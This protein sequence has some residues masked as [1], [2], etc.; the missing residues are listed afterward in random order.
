MMHRLLLSLVL[1][2]CCLP[3]CSTL[4]KNRQV[5]ISVH[6]QGTEMANPKSIFKR[7][8]GGR[9]MIFQTLPVFTHNNVIAFHPFPAD[10]GTNGVALK[11]DFKGTHAL[12]M[13]TRMRRGEVLMA[14]VNLSVVD[15][16]NIDQAVSD[17][18]FT[19]WQGIPDELIAIMD[20]K[21]SRIKDVSSASEMQEMTP[22]TT[23]E[24]KDIKR[25]AEREK[26]E[27][28]KREAEAAKR[29]ARGEFMPELP[30]GELLPM[31][32]Q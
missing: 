11:L 18:I 20:K 5:I 9:E 25:R 12:D 28:A 17:G 19:I 2:S 8:I 21:Y 31:P 3:A 23:Q 10:N 29:R 13:A 32:Q 4:K 6:S 16:V 1:L 15:I 24:K 27:Q 30:P 22:S 26:K 14:M 7:R